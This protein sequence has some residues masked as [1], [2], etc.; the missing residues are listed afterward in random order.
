MKVKLKDVAEAAGVSVSTVSRVI[1]GNRDKP[2]SHETVEKIWAIVEEI[3]YVPNKNAKNLVLGEGEEASLGRIGC[4][5]T[6]TYDLNNDPFFSCIGLGVQKALNSQN[7]NMAYAL[8]A[9]LMDYKDLYRYIVNHPADGI[10]VLGRFDA[11]I[12]TMLKNHFKHMV[13]AGVNSVDAGFDEVI[14][15]GYDGAKAALQHLFDQGHHRIGYVGYVADKVEGD[16]LVNEHRYNAYCDLMTAVNGQVRPEDI[17]HTNLRTTASYERMTLYLEGIGK[18]AMPT[19]FYCANDATAFGV[20][21]ALQEK[22]YRIPEDVAI[23]GLDN[24]EMAAFVTP[25][26]S[27][28]SIPQRALGERAVKMLI[29]QIETQRSYPLKVKLPFELIVRESSDYKVSVSG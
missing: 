24:V 11:H 14:C 22:A 4:I 17:L 12:L 28:I 7:Y 23:V 27:T 21:K 9:A 3:G 26:L 29:E 25:R 6:S 20:M 19:A 16:V 15:D 10:I 5:Y 2:A 13:Y 1:N 8:S 18:Q